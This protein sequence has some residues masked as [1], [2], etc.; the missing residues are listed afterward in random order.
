MFQ[1]PLLSSVPFIFSE[2]WVGSWRSWDCDTQWGCY[3][4]FYFWLRSP[5]LLHCSQPDQ[6]SLQL[7]TCNPPLRLSC[8]LAMFLCNFRA[9]TV[10]H[11]CNT[12]CCG[13]LC[14]QLWC[15]I[16][17]L[18]QPLQLPFVR[19]LTIPHLAVTIDVNWATDLLLTLLS[20]IQSCLFCLT[21]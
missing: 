3:S 6:G 9:S 17:R 12:G 1:L 13:S 21:P 16:H 7:C 14:C 10:I 8:P 4:S 18:P 11:P 2:L 19:C 15:L 20:L 5:P